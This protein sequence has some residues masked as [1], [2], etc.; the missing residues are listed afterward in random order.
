MDFDQLLALYE[1][2]LRNAARK[3]CPNRED[4]EDLYQDTLIKMWRNLSDYRGDCPFLPWAYQIMRNLSID[5]YRTEKRHRHYSLE[6][7]TRGPKRE[8]P[9]EPVDPKPGPYATIAARSVVSDALS[10]LR[11]PYRTAFVLH[12]LNESDSKVA[13]A[14]IGI[15]GSTVRSRTQRARRILKS[16]LSEVS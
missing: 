16:I 8:E 6:Q 9:W 10:R 13:A 3:F 2:P 1:K 4:A 11:E 14:H 7:M 5:R 12:V 15:G